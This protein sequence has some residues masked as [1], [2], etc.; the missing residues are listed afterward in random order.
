MLNV[1]GKLS[2]GIGPRRMCVCMCV[3]VCERSRGTVSSSR[4]NSTDNKK[5]SVLHDSYGLLRREG[6]REGG[7]GGGEAEEGRMKAC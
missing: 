5:P 1:N 3:H 4:I 7:V 6:G 2:D